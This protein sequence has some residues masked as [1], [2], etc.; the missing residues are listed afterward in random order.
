[1]VH[2]ASVAV[3]A[4]FIARLTLLIVDNICTLV[5]SGML[6]TLLLCFP[7]F[8]SFFSSAKRFSPNHE[9]LSCESLSFP[10]Y[11]ALQ[12][13]RHGDGEKKFLASSD[14][15]LLLCDIALKTTWE[16]IILRFSW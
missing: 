3:C 16:K 5:K 14:F 13:H 7:L 8:L 2:T 15:F 12:A 6:C 1:M 10:L 9:R 11:V 4:L